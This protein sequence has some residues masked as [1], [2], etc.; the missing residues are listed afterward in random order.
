MMDL[1]GLEE[2]DEL[3]HPDAAGDA[4][5]GQAEAAG[6]AEAGENENPPPKDPEPGA[7]TDGDLLGS[8]DDLF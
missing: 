6:D 4:E 3:L 7:E 8:D 1:F 2:D 5:P